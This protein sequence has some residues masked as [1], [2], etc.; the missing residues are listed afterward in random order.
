M[1]DE[2]IEILYH[3]PRCPVPEAD[4]PGPYPGDT[5]PLPGEDF[6]ITPECLNGVDWQVVDVVLAEMD[7]GDPFQDLEVP[8]YARNKNSTISQSVKRVFS[9]VYCLLMTC[10]VFTAII[11]VFFSTCGLLAHYSILFKVLYRDL[12]GKEFGR[13]WLFREVAYVSE[14]FIFM[15]FVGPGIYWYAH[16]EDAPLWFKYAC[17]ITMPLGYALICTNVL[18]AINRCCIVTVPLHYKIIFSNGRIHVLLGAICVLSLIL[19]IPSLIPRCVEIDSVFPFGAG[20][21]KS[22]EWEPAYVER[23][24]GETRDYID[25]GMTTLFVLLTMVMDGVTFRGV[26]RISKH[27]KQLQ[28]AGPMKQELKLCNMIVAQQAICIVSSAVFNS[29]FFW[30]QSWPNREHFTLINWAITI[31]LDGIVVVLFTPKFMKCPLEGIVSH[32]SDKIES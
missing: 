23:V 26:R 13:L 14:C 3:G 25:F 6:G 1:F 24:C 16:Y 11:I 10:T 32:S 5:M 12:F 27:R 4:T 18:I 21:G 22:S 8:S 15:F 9:T 29:T 17:K 19:G 30:F 28:L 31:L 2:E 7:G 20:H